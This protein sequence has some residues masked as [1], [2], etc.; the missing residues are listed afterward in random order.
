MS[1]SPF[2]HDQML[3]PLITSLNNFVFENWWCRNNKIHGKFLT[4]LTWWRRD[5][6]FPFKQILDAALAQGDASL[7][8]V[9]VVLEVYSYEGWLR[10]CEPGQ[11]ETKTGLLQLFIL[12]HNSHVSSD[13]FSASLQCLNT[14]LV[15]GL[16][17]KVKEVIHGRYD[18][19]ISIIMSSRNVPFD[20]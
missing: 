6:I 15:E 5:V 2:C 4:K 10:S 3:F 8:R 19:I 12:Q 11:E 20:L 13:T 16:I 18:I 1:W 14:I 7:P 17:L 9:Q